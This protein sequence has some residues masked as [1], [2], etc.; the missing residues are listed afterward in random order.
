MPKDSA[1]LDAAYDDALGV[2]AAFNLNALRHVNALLGTDFDVRDWLHRGFTT[3][4]WA[5]SRCTSKRGEVNV[6]VRGH[7]RRFA[8]GE[9]IHTENSYKFTPMNFAPCWLRP[10]LKTPR[11]WQD[12]QGD[13]SVFYATT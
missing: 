10:A 6:K 7:T 8:A 1:R 12:T 5:A 9:R 2:T 3:R 4:R 13:F 11:L